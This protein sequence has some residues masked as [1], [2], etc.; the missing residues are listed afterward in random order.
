MKLH[1]FKKLGMGLVLIKS[2]VFKDER[3]FFLEIYDKKEF[4]KANIKCNFIQSMVSVSKSGVMR[5]LHFQ[6]GKYAQAKLVRCLSGMVWEVA[7]DV[8][9][10]SKTFG[11]YVAIELSGKDMNAVF[12]PR[13]FALGFIVLSKEDAVLL[14]NVENE[15]SPAHASGVRWN[16]KNI[17]IKWPITPKIISE[18]DR[19]LSELKYL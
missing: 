5:G 1:K 8:R 14:Y 16:D 11:K 19:N 4:E 18:K 9:K 15:Y 6:K 7:V 2:S 17:N 10:N 13:G 12:V 3:G